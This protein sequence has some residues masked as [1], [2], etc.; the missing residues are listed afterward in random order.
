VTD[1]Y[2]SRRG[3][4]RPAAKMTAERVRAMRHRRETEQ[5]RPS[6]AALARDFGVSTATAH[7]I[8]TRRYW[9]HVT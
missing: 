3:E 6:I 7:A 4:A 5:P 2:A 8:L 1:P 9:S